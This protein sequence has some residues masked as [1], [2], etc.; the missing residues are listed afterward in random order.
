MGSEMF[1]AD[2]RI[3]E[4]RIR[5]KMEIDLGKARRWDAACQ[6]AEGVRDQQY[7]HRR[8]WT[9][10]FLL[11][12]FLVA[13]VG[14]FLIAAVLHK[15]DYVEPSSARQGAVLSLEI[16]AL[17]WI[18][19]V[20]VRARRSETFI[21]RRRAV[22][23]PLNRAERRR[24]VE[25]WRGS[26]PVAVE[27]LPVVKA[28]AI[29]TMTQIDFQFRLMCGMVLLVAGVFLNLDWR[30]TQFIGAAAFTLYTVAALLLFRDRRRITG[31]FQRNES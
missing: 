7:G 2:R 24:V 3:H 23:S 28:A 29:Q 30:F 14:G 18:V 22:L 4:G 11:T 17:V 6:L 9:W 25:Q 15:G 5:K 12:A 31:F 16:L 26:V 8:A 27:E 21:T 10:I 19:S 20:T 1:Y 13:G